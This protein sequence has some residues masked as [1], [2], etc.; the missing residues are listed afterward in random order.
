MIDSLQDVVWAASFI[1]KL[2]LLVIFERAWT[3]VVAEMAALEAC[4][5]FLDLCCIFVVA[6]FAV[7]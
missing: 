4:A 1:L 3:A 5:V 7:L 6:L 2:L